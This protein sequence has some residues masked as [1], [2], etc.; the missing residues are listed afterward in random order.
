M[1][2]SNTEP[3]WTKCNFED[4]PIAKAL[5][6]IDDAQCHGFHFKLAPSGLYF[7]EDPIENV[8]VHNMLTI[9]ICDNA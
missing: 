7:T 2:I 8:F 3:V 1:E 4:V 6:M 9:K 5:E